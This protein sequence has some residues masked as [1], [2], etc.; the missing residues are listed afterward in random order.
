MT[1]PNPLLVMHYMHTLTLTH[2]NALYYLSLITTT[3]YNSALNACNV[4]TV[5]RN[6]PLSA[7]IYAMLSRTTIHF[8]ISPLT[9]NL[10]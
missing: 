6:T 7:L 1:T 4:K 5:M 2:P 9:V 3:L 8:S 10:Y